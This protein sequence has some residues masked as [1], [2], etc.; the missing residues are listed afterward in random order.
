MCQ[1]VDFYEY[2]YCRKDNFINIFIDKKSALEIK[3]LLIEKINDNKISKDYR[4]AYIILRDNISRSINDKAYAQL[5]INK[6][7]LQYLKDLYYDFYERE[8]SNNIKE[9]IGQI[10]YFIK[11]ETQNIYKFYNLNENTKI[12]ILSRI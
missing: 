6:C 10:Q 8:E 5:R 4:C 3:S 11:D 9:L 12:S 2:K 1:I 7:F